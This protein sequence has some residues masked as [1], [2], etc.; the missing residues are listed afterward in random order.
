MAWS[1]CGS[2]DMSRETWYIQLER[3]E[4]IDFVSRGLHH[5]PRY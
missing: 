2:E 1:E 3:G 5:R 4:V